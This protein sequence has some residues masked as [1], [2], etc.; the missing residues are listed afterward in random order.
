MGKIVVQHDPRFWLYRR[1]FMRQR[2]IRDLLLEVVEEPWA[3]RIDFE[4]GAPIEETS[5]LTDYERREGD[6][7]WQ[8][9]RKDERKPLYVLLKFQPRPDPSM[10]VRF[11]ASVGLFYR[12]LMASQPAAPWGKLPP[13]IPILLYSG[14][15]PWKVTTMLGSWIGNLDPSAEIYRPQMCYR[16]VS[17]VTHPLERL[18]AL[19]SPVAELFRIKKSRDWKEVRESLSRLRQSI[20]ADEESLRGAF[21][22]WMQVAIL[23][24]FGLFLPDLP[25]TTPLEEIEAL[26]SESA[27]ESRQADYL[28][29]FQEGVALMMLT[30]LRSKLGPLE[31]DVE[32]RI[33]S[34]DADLLLE[35]SDRI[36]TAES[37]QDVFRD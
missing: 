11:M 9:D 17:E 13:V 4:F 8:F 35:W 32:D 23:P 1:L 34:T 20:P 33:R 12:S 3:E 19:N 24:R 27:L 14:R 16:L 25:T 21:V 10:P 36:P 15:I 26:L 30:L 6:V 7:L 31:A 37:L 18:T 29:G 22:A 28:E 2:I 5:S